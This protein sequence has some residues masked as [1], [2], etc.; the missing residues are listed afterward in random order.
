MIK[1]WVLGY[2]DSLPFKSSED[3]FEYA[4]KYFGKDKLSL[5]SSFIGIVR[6]VDNVED[7]PVYRVDII[8]KAGNFFN[9]QSSKTV[10]AVKHPDLKVVI[11][12]NDL[13]IFGPDNISIKIPT[14]F[15]LYKL[16]PELDIKTK[17]FKRYNSEEKIPSIKQKNK[18][19]ETGV[20]LWNFEFEI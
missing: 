9:K 12:E 11:K 4:Q 2:M 18:A 20:D 19:F 16:I 3:A 14:G 6:F 17:Q 15:L 7:P 13:V 10:V 5:K 1:K 8:C